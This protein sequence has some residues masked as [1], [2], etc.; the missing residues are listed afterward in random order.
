MWGTR[1]DDPS[2][3]RIIRVYTGERGWE[4][5]DRDLRFTRETAEQLR[6]GGISMVRVRFSVNRVR[7]VSTSSSRALR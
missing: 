4:P 3:R 6:S 1:S 2:R 5:A 7:E